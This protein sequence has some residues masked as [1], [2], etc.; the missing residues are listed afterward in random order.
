MSWRKV[1][2]LELRRRAL[3]SER[4]PRARGT[5]E[6]AERQDWEIAGLWFD[7]R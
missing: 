5:E 6:E 2:M 7:L 4:E 1:A 3:L